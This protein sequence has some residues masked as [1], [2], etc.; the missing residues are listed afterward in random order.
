MFDVIIYGEDLEQDIRPLVKAFLPEQELQVVYHNML[1]SSFLE[2][3]RNIQEGWQGVLLFLLEERFAIISS[4]S[5]KSNRIFTDQLTEKEL[6]CSEKEKYK[7]YR[8]RLLRLLYQVLYEKTGKTLPWGILTGVR[9]V[10]LIFDLL[11]HGR[12]EQEASDFMVQQY[13]IEADRLHLGLQ[14][15]KQERRLLKE[16]DYKNGYSLYIGI[17]FCPSICHYCSFSSF[18]LHQYKDD[19]EPYLTALE[20]EITYAST[21]FPDQELHTIYFGGGTPTTL[22]AEQLERLLLLVKNRF[23]C[24]HLRELTVEAGR[25]D[26]ITK[27]KLLVLKEQDVTRISINPQSM[28]DHTLRLIG[29]LHTAALTEEVFYMA[30]EVGHN[31]INMDL[32]IGLTGENLSDVRHTLRCVKGMQPDSLTVHTLSV[33]RAARLNTEKQQ[34]QGMEATEVEEMMGL[35]KDFAKTEGYSPYYLYRQKNMKENLENI[36]YSKQGKEGLYNILIMEEKQKILALGAGASSK[37]V[38][39]GENRFERVENVKSIPEYIRRIDE[40]IDR[41]KSFLSALQNR[42]EK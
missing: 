15:A 5:G 41:K 30:R 42:K 4:V 23:D 38:F 3:V 40:M 13:L 31:N 10:K 35:A 12:D 27:E 22:E 25:P 32:I 16:L 18:P 29:R 17:P 36:G 19:V 6:L 39:H 24:S 34:Y 1:P 21:C 28:Q 7:H 26:S 37:F 2:R 8:N 11:E 9:P 33:K 14:V 20:K